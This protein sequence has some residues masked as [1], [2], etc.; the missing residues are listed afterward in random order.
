MMVGSQPKWLLFSW[1][2]HPSFTLLGTGL[3]HE[4][5]E[6]TSSQGVRRVR[7]EDSVVLLSASDLM[8]FMG[9]RYATKLDLRYAKGDKALVPRPGTDEEELLRRIGDGHEAGYLERLRERT[10]S[11]VEVARGNLPANAEATREAMAAGAGIIYQGALRDGSWGGWTDFLERVDGRPSALGDYSYE[12]VDTKLRRKPHPKHVLQLVLYS[13]MLTVAQGSP[14]QRTHLEL[15]NGTRTS[16][17]LA[18]YA[19]YARQARTRLE[20]FIEEPESVTPT[21]CPDCKLCRWSDHCDDVWRSSDSLYLVASMTTKQVTRLEAAGVRTMEALATRQQPVRGIQK[22]TLDRLSAQARLQH[23]RKSGPPCFELRPVAPGRG[24]DLLPPA[25]EGDLF[26]DI[27]GDPY[28]DGGLEYLHGV[29]AG[30]GYA[31]FWAHDS[32]SEHSSL[33]ALLGFFHQHLSEFPNA[34]IYHYA[35]YEITALRR[36]CARYGT[37]EAYLDQLMRERRFVDL[38]AVVKGA[39]LTS[40]GSYSLKALEI[41][42]NFQRT[43]EVRTAG[44]SVVA[45]EEWRETGDHALLHEIEVYNREDCAS[46]EE[47]RD[48][49]LHLRPLNRPPPPAAVQATADPVRPSQGEDDALLALLSASGLPVDRQMLLYNLAVF[50]QREKKPAQWAVFESVTKDPEELIDDL[51]AIGDLTATGPALPS[52]Q[53]VVRHYSFPPQPTKLRAKTQA[54]IPVPGGIP[55]VTINELDAQ[56]G[57]VSLQI[58]GDRGHLLGN[59]LSLHPAWPRETTAIENS[60]RKVVADQCGLRRFTAINDLLERSVPRLSG[61]ALRDRDPGDDLVPF[62]IQA[63]RDMQGSVLAIQGPPGTGKT[64]LAA[65]IILSLASDGKRIGVTS[66]SHEAIRNLLVACEVARGQFTAS[67]PRDFAIAHKVTGRVDYA[68][69][70][71][72]ARPTDNKAAILRQA[73][74]VGGTAFF[75]ARDAVRQAFDWLIVDEAGQVSLANL[76]AMGRAAKNIVLVGDPQQLPQVIQAA[77]PSPADLS[78]LEWIIAGQ[79]KLPRER[80][81]FLDKTRRMHPDLCSFISE[82]VYEG[83]LSHVPETARQQVSGTRYPAAGAFW[84][85]VEHDG[86]TQEAPE[87]VVAVQQAIQHLLQGRW[88]DKTG[89][90]RDLREAD[91]IVVAPFNAQVHAL[92]AALPDGI[93]VGTVDK[94]QG[95][96]APVCLVSM[97]ASRADSARGMEFLLSLN[98][99]NVAIS[100]A[101]ALTMVFGAPRLRETVCKTVEQMRLVNMLCALPEAISEGQVARVSTP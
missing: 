100:R 59:H 56:A 53:S 88:K 73:T 15:G 67:L 64:Y 36:L 74:I 76:V 11:I 41:F 46:T 65:Q 101:K 44:A 57:T 75:F 50:H 18:D 32:P 20:E 30:D 13:D 51:D 66:N 60:L 49:L 2:M 5:Q 24:F 80:G 28:F 70:S 26:Y 35:P 92:R 42:Y 38:Y 8:R 99:L 96:E 25:Q 3:C 6:V 9:C 19:A 90:T 14:P 45:Y 12:V 82:Q 78:C 34:R 43:A 48:W 69:S 77:H 98:R 22:P 93:R 21:P 52:G 95:Q 94:F 10:A 29:K 40:E 63:V 39:L 86:N 33:Q 31:A 62:A 83:C 81:I 55:F 72:I 71:R 23:A 87:E 97:S 27:E 16:F 89:K 7:L 37:G 47:L 61:L 54:T 68:P 85:P 84:V 1:N 17:R 4:R 79:A 58:R 91:I